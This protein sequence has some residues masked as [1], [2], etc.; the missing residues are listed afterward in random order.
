MEIDLSKI[1][2]NGRHRKDMGDLAALASSIDEV[3]LLHPLVVTPENHLVAG[4]RRLEALKTMGRKRAPVHVVAGLDEALLLLG[5]ERDENTCRKDFTLSEVVAMEDSL[6]PLQEIK[7]KEEHC[8][9]SSEGGK[10]GGKKAGRGR[11]IEGRKIL[12]TPKRKQDE[13]GRTAAKTAEAVGHSRITMA[14]ARQIVE[15]ASADPQTFAPLV[16][17]MD[18]I[19]KVNGAYEKMKRIQRE[20]ERGKIATKTL[21]KIAGL[22]VGDFR[23]VL[24]DL[25]D[26]S[27]DLIFTDPPYDKGSLSLYGDLAQLGLRVLAEGGSLA[28]YAGQYALPSIF[29]LMTPHL[30][31]QWA[32]AVRHSGGHRRMHGW[33]VRVRWKPLLWFAKG[34]Y[35]GEY[36][37]D[38]LDSKPGDK[39]AHDHAQGHAEAVY[40]IENLCP[41]GGMVLDPMCGS[42]TTL[43]AAKRLSR[44]F[45]GVEIDKDTACVANAMLEA[46]GKGD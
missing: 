17:E 42:G 6:R 45:I 25:P 30:R 31:Y 46:D 24:A 39:I 36:L 35:K 44:K 11:P 3:G 29:P 32:F 26:N 23:E 27:I 41:R 33:R 40:L 21:R 8:K 13:K 43:V 19:G 10:E 12:P 22:H 5:A 15:A 37:I 1:I 9:K 7:T 4:Q 16:E 28:C 34:Q 14:R 20:R 18:R 2:V 38:M